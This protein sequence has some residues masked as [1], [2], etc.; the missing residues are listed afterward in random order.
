MDQPP[1]MMSAALDD[2]CSAPDRLPGTVI[3]A[4]F[5]PHEHAAPARHLLNTAYTDG[6]GDQMDVAEWWGSLRADPEFDQRLCLCLFD[7]RAGRMLG[8]AQSWTTGF[9]KDFAI[10]PDYQ[11]QGLGR[12]LFALTC[13]RLSNFG[14]Q[15]ISL[16]VV[17]NNEGAIRFYRAM[18]MTLYREQKTRPRPE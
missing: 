7:R 15:D 10:A 2:I 9:L 8:F 18:G 4:D 12:G 16:K 13:A 5:I 1:V 14:V 3:P 17:A 6:V 11:G